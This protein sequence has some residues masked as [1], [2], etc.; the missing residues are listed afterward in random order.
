MSDETDRQA[1]KDFALW[2]HAPGGPFHVATGV[3]ASKAVTALDLDRAADA[4][5][6]EQDPFRSVQ[7]DDASAAPPGKDNGPRQL[8]CTCAPGRLSMSC[9]VGRQVGNHP[10]GTSVPEEL[11]AICGH[12]GLAHIGEHAP[13]HINDRKFG[14]VP[15]HESAGARR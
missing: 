7:Q 4:F 6:N 1:L 8:Q 3:D 15:C 13:G 9:E 2:L 14:I 12:P 10:A 5:L 11:C